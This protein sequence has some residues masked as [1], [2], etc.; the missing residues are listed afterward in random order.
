MKINKAYKF[1]LEPTKEQ[2]DVLFM[3]VGHARFV[4]NNGLRFC[5]DE[6][7]A[8]RKVPSAFDMH[9]LLTQWKKEPEMFWLKDAYS[10]NLQQKLTDL[11]DAWKRCFN[12]S[13]D[14]IQPKFKKKGKHD[15]I[16]FTGFKAN[17]KLDNKRVKLPKFKDFIKFR[18]SREIEGTIKQCTV[19]YKSGHW[20][21]S[22]LTE[23]EINPVNKSTSPIGVDLGIANFATLSDGTS[24]APLNCFRKTQDKLAKEQRKLSK[25]KK[26]SQN[27]HKQLSKVQKIHTKIANTRS[28]YLHKV[29]TEISKNHAMVAIE[30]LKIRNMS[31]SAKGNQE[32]HGKNVAAKS[33]LNKSILDQG[34][35]NI[36]VML[37]YK[38]AWNNGIVVAVPPQ[39]TSQTCPCCNHVSEENRQTQ[40]HFECVR[41]GFS[42]NA[43]VIGAV[44]VLERGHRL[45]ACGESALVV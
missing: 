34:W 16:R 1:R 45:L 3:L 37:E 32:K 28:D 27:W 36:R 19:S 41:C 7:E 25:K 6:L 13:L 39:Y 2:A 35:Y 14:S 18:K 30:D 31:K 42:G 5:L 4:W 24:Y 20:Y 9:K 29:S 21:I 40:A 10:I 8:G 43:D 23:Q 22:F 15:S 44:N 33:G 26:F 17:C 38:A 11:S 12:K